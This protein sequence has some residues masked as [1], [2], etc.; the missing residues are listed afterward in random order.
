MVATIVL[1]MPNAIIDARQRDWPR[2]VRLA[3]GIDWI[4]LRV[5]G[6][7]PSLLGLYRLAFGL[8]LLDLLVVI[9]AACANTGWGFLIFAS[10]IIAVLGWCL[11]ENFSVRTLFLDARKKQITVRWGLLILFT[12]RVVPLTNF[13]SLAIYRSKGTLSGPS[14]RLQLEGNRRPLTVPYHGADGYQLARH[15]GFI[16]GLPVREIY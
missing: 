2:G 4:D 5:G 7:R 3:S 16:A 12:K 9:A 11:V 8:F 10:P 14:L 13:T 1:G 15:I 6:L